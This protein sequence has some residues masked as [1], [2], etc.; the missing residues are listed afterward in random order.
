MDVSMCPRDQVASRRNAQPQI[1]PRA[2]GR[3]RES[4]PPE[5]NVIPFCSQA[6]LA[7]SDGG[8]RVQAE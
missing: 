3:E 7:L 8:D 5:A 2:R 1:G 6:Q 4:Y